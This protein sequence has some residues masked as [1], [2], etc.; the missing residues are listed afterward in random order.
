MIPSFDPWTSADKDF[1]KAI[2]TTDWHFPEGLE[3]HNSACRWVPMIKRIGTSSG[4][5]TLFS[6]SHCCHVQPTVISTLQGLF[7]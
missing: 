4:F 7:S 1:D 6:G 3:V 5:S 2:P